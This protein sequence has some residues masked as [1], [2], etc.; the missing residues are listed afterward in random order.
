MC[1]F[2]EKEREGDPFSPSL[3]MSGSE[4]ELIHTDNEPTVKES[5]K[6]VNQR[7]NLSLVSGDTLSPSS[8]CPCTL[9]PGAR[10]LHAVLRRRL[11][12]D[13]RQSASPHLPF[14]GQTIIMT[15][16]VPPKKFAAVH[17]DSQPDKRP[18]GEA[19]VPP[20]PLFLSLSLLPCPRVT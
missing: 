10:E 17:P 18:R 9:F 5:V 7:M 12:S 19:A 6:R 16:V 20:D 3:T 2:A 1:S 11:M 13:G 14:N 4:R 8:L 15:I